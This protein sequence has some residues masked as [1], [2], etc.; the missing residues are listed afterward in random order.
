VA[1]R[2]LIND[3]FSIFFLLARCADAY[4]YCR[5]RANRMVFGSW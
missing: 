3:F 5:W 1:A 2:L 4:T